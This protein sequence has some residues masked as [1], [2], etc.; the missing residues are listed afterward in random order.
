[1]AIDSAVKRSSAIN[2]RSPWRG[3][4]P[5]PDGTTTPA[6]RA[7]VVYLYGGLAAAAASDTTPDQ[8]SGET[9]TGQA[10]SATV[11][12]AAVTPVGYDTATTIS[13][14]GGTYSINGG[15]YTASAGTLSP[16]DTFTARNTSSGSYLTGVDTVITL[17]GSV[18]ATYRSITLG[19][20]AIQGYIR[21]PF[22]FNWW[23]S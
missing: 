20:P 23:K 12:F 2:P 14:T 13:I 11:T 3:I 8:F 9:K 6:E 15:A 21:R 16:G 5:I 10:L 4:L 17:D 18:S 7:T 19:D 22:N 1:M